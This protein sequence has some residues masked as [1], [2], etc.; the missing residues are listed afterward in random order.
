MIVF[1]TLLGLLATGLMAGM[2]LGAEIERVG[3]IQTDPGL[4][5]SYQLSG[6]ILPGDADRLETVLLG[7]IAQLDTYPWGTTERQLVLCLEGPGGSFLEALQIAEFV[8]SND[9]TTRVNPNESCLSACAIAFLGGNL[10]TRSGEGWRAS[11]FIHPTSRLG[12]HAPELVLPDGQFT[13]EDVGRAYDIAIEAVGLITEQAEWLRIPQPL[14][15]Q[16]FNHR[17]DDFHIVETIDH[18]ATYDF[19]LYGYS[20]PRLTAETRRYA[21]ENAWTWSLESAPSATLEDYIRTT[22]N[23]ASF[24]DLPGGVVRFSP[25]DGFLYCEV[26]EAAL[27]GG[28]VDR[29]RASESQTFQSLRVNATHPQWV[30]YPGPLPLSEVF[31]GTYRDFF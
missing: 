28:P 16:M 23:P 20:P 10:N 1:R 5:C 12:F 17:G 7:E 26:E 2:A 14:L 29:I 3:P 18:L 4:G 21:C 13:R 24:A 30:R 25:F 6:Q 15:T 22:R 19:L 31:L 27:G 8:R 9:I 11:R